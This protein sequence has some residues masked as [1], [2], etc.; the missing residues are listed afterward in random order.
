M[1]GS[2]DEILK[3]NLILNKPMSV[4]GEDAK[5]DQ[6]LDSPWI[7]DIT[8]LSDN[9]LNGDSNE[10]SNEDLDENEDEHFDKGLDEDLDVQ[11]EVCEMTQ[12]AKVT[13]ECGL[14]V[15]GYD[16]DA[17]THIS[18]DFW[19]DLE[20]VKYCKEDMVHESEILVSGEMVPVILPQ[21]D[22][23]VLKVS[24]TTPIQTDVL[25]ISNQSVGDD[26]SVAFEENVDNT[27]SCDEFFES[28]EPT[29]SSYDQEVN[30]NN[31][32]GEEGV[33]MEGEVVLA[34]WNDDGWYFRGKIVERRTGGFL[35]EDNGGIKE[36]I[37]LEHVFFN[38]K[39]NYYNSRLCPHDIITRVK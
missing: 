23:P 18:N 9:D 19:D 37:D 4:I 13:L 31:A 5:L 33:H 16:A 2:L 8:N 14:Q 21:I 12:M 6:M 24:T 20:K 22:I 39:V 29:A 7:N 35:V 11:S 1:A 38:D 34:R 30:K 15:G 17:Q 27:L 28:T 32:I 3:S 26:Q 25:S 36:E 10:G